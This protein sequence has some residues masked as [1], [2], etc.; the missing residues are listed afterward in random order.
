MRRAATSNHQ[1]GILRFGPAAWTLLAD[2]F[3]RT[4]APGNV[5]EIQALSNQWQKAG[6][7]AQ[8]VPLPPQ[9]A[10]LDELKNTVRG[11]F[12]WPFGGS[13]TVSQNLTSS[14]IPTERNRWK[15]SNY[16]GYSSAVYDELYDRFAVTIAA[17]ER[18]RIFVEA[19]RFLAEEVPIISIYCYGN[20]VIARKGLAGVGLAAPSQSASAWNIHT[21]EIKWGIVPLAQGYT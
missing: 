14:V 10:N 2:T 9:S 3:D 18:Q 19:L 6:I 13:P 17:S 12:V 15:G 1:V 16:G 11:A 4:R 21:W 8:P 5:N 20:A 7:G